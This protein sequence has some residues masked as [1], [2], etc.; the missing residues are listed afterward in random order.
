MNGKIDCSDGGFIGK[1][2]ASWK[3][4]IKNI[5]LRPEKIKFISVKSKG[6]GIP[7]RLGPGMDMGWKFIEIFPL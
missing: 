3:L 2:K 5:G 7:V 6:K 1:L 4:V